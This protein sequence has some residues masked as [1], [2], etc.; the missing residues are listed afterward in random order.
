MKKLKV[1]LAIGLLGLIISKGFAN[2]ILQNNFLKVSIVTNGSNAGGISSIEN[3]LSGINYTFNTS[4]NEIL[5]LM[6]ADDFK[7]QSLKIRNKS[8]AELDIETHYTLAQNNEEALIVFI[9]YELINDR[10]KIHF[11]F[12][13]QRKMRL[14]HYIEIN[15]RM[16]DITGILPLNQFSVDQPIDIKRESRPYY[17]TLNQIYQFQGENAFLNFLITNPYESLV[18]IKKEPD[19]LLKFSFVVLPAYEPWKAIEPKG[20]KIASLIDETSILD[21]TCEVFLTQTGTDLPLLSYFSPFPNAFDQVISMIFDEVPFYRWLIPPSTDPKDI[22]GQNFLIRLLKDHPKMKMS[23]VVIPDPITAPDG[24]EN[25]DYPKGKWWL[26]HGVHRIATYAPEA[27][28]RWMRHLEQDSVVLGYENRVH[29]GDHG[30]H[31]TPEGKFGKN[32]EFQ[33]FD[34]LRD[35]RTMDA[36]RTDFQMIGLTNKSLKFIRFPGFKFTRSI[37][38]AL[39][40][41]D[42]SGFDFDLAWEINRL[43]LFP[44][45]VAS[46]HLWAISANWEGDTPLTY[47]RMK[48]YLQRGKWVHTAGHPIFWFNYGDESAYQIRNK[49]FRQAEQDFPNLGY[50]YFD[51]YAAIAND[52]L[53]MKN[54][55]FAYKKYVIQISFS[56]EMGHNETIVVQPVRKDSLAGQIT[57]DDRPIMKYRIENSRLLIVLPNLGKGDH[58]V[59][60]PYRNPPGIYTQKFPLKVFPNPS[61]NGQLVNI[62]NI[63]THSKVFILNENG[64]I[65]KT[66]GDRSANKN[67]IWDLTTDN[68]EFVPGGVYVI[69]FKN[70]KNHKIEM[71][72]IAVVR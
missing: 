38:D 66:F 55:Q 61:V 42:Y 64:V 69:I 62:L 18:E 16:R 48:D 44:Y 10:L 51:E 70:T 36:V 6:N 29:L 35:E 28:K 2:E 68:N 60:I 11:R 21:F 46:K 65:I 24:L 58:T 41:H 27:Y 59:K 3:K 12:L 26:A 19:G 13:P 33:T 17:Q 47:A 22:S 53:G 30:Y 8:Y 71:Q 14:N 52:L 49:I 57:I 43:P 39:A 31:H 4:G 50:I 37:L 67:L 34:S 7:F 32:W 40:H 9:H 63:P 25:P 45:Y 72:K 5:F 1:L 15:S 20:P 23:W 56:G 54:Y